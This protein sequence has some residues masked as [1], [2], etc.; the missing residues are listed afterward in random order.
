[1]KKQTLSSND[2]ARADYQ[3]LSW[4]V[5]QD[6]CDRC[7]TYRYGLSLW[8]HWRHPPVMVGFYCF[9]CLDGSQL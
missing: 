4:I 8:T 3:Q 7:G 2:N 9:A 1:M 5:E 6:A